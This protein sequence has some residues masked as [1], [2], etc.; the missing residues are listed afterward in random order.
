L[1]RRCCQTFGEVP[2][3]RDAVDAPKWLNAS[4]VLDCCP[5]IAVLTEREPILGEYLIHLHSI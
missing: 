2:Q 4:Q 5:E 3:V 1:E